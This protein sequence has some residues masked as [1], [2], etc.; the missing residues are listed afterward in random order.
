[1]PA[2]LPRQS[3]FRPDRSGGDCRRKSFVNEPRGL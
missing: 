2:A 1:L 3:G